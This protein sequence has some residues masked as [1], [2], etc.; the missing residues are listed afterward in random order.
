MKG[1][2]EFIS[3]R[4]QKVEGRVHAH[5]RVGKEHYADVI[6]ITRNVLNL[7]LQGDV[8]INIG[9]KTGEEDEEMTSETLSSLCST[10]IM[11]VMNK[12]KGWRLM[13]SDFS[14]IAL[15]MMFY[16]TMSLGFDNIEKLDDIVDRIAKAVYSMFQLQTLLK[17]Q[18]ENST[19]LNGQ[20]TN[21]LD[22]LSNRQ[23]LLH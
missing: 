9:K 12:A 23:K 17:A 22:K 15:Q 13:E 6:E 10:E 2:E 19:T 1:V 8:K 14:S 4:T 7:V 5:N 16:A 11:L 20:A 3:H 21:L 18:Y